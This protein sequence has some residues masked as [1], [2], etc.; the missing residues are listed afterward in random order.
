MPCLNTCFL[1]GYRNAHLSSNS[2]IRVIE[3]QTWLVMKRH[4]FHLKLSTV[5]YNSVFA[6]K[7][8]NRQGNTLRVSRCFMDILHY[9]ILGREFKRG[10]TTVEV[11]ARSERPLGATDEEICKNVWVLVYSDRRI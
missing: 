10:R 1:R 6:F 9:L 11:K 8:L 7:R 4:A 5:L 2:L 3:C